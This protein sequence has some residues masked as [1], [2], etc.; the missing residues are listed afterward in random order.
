MGDGVASRAELNFRKMCAGSAECLNYIGISKLA[1]PGAP[2]R[3]GWV[4]AGIPK[5]SVG[6]QIAALRIYSVAAWWRKSR[7]AKDAAGVQIFADRAIWGARG[8]R[9]RN[10]LWRGL[11]IAT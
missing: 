11:L 5:G 7:I 6:S 8:G 10:P 4:S 1:N 2:P 9:G 3:G